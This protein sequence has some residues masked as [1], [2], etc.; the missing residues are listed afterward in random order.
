MLTENSCAI[1]IAR[2]VP[3]TRGIMATKR[4]LEKAA[5]TTLGAEATCLAWK[6]NVDLENTNREN[7]QIFHFGCFSMTTA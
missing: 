2:A 1:C 4:M 7:I 6:E 5:G 3:H